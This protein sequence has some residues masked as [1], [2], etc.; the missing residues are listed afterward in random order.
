[1]SIAE[2][3]KAR[4]DILD[5]VTE[6]VPLQRSGA[7]YRASCPFHSEKTPSFFVFPSRQT[8]RCFGACATGGDSFSFLM[9][10]ENLDFGQALNL[11]AQKTGLDLPARRSVNQDDPLFRINEAASQFFSQYLS[12]TEGQEALEYLKK[13]RKLTPKIIDIFHLGFSP[14][15]GQSLKRHL[16]SL[17]YQEDQ[18]VLAGLLSQNRYGMHQDLFRR[19]IMFPIFDPK[20]RPVGFGGRVLD[21]SSPKYLNSR[22][23]PIFDKGRILYAYHKAQEHIKAQGVVV[24]EGYMDAIVAHQEG[25][26]NV[27]A[28][29]GTSLTRNQAMLLQSIAQQVV[30]ALDPDTAGQNATLRSLESSWEVFQRRVISASRN[31]TLYERPGGP[32]L[33]VASLPD[34]KDPDAIIL[35][36]PDIWAMLT[37]KAV[38]LLDFLF[39]SLSKRYD[40]STPQGKAQIADLIFPL[41]AA[42]P[43]PFE[44]DQRFRDLAQLLGVS[45]SALEASVARRRTPRRVI[46][47][48][49]DKASSS[50]FERLERDSLE[51]HCLALLFQNPTL[52][53]TILDLRSE[54][55]Q[56]IEN[57]EAFTN[58]LK[59]SKIET[60]DDEINAHITYLHKK[61]L[62]SS[63]I[64]EKEAVLADCTRR[65]EERRLRGLKEEEGLRLSQMNLDEVHNQADDILSINADMAALFRSR[66]R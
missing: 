15:D 51:E 6:Y 25:F 1:M 14:S 43:D 16:L 28:S 60:L 59:D 64:K 57:R 32:D 47:S 44:Q 45:E 8:W 4:L 65:L 34:G 23:S 55:F 5:L 37:T 20:G 9:R 13:E 2:D 53:N 58:W 39:Q 10:I 40:P 3:I 48:R 22:Q 26:Q 35:D 17:G 7:N 52:K 63:D 12:S 38:P 49:N 33:R 36:D 42:T 27:V 29:M 56:M 30:L 24:V 61:S 19:R 50:P 46:N 31:S 54:H 41:V 66:S 62:P 11:L 18:L 21:N